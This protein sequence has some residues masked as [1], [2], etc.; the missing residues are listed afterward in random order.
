M[1]MVFGLRIKDRLD[2]ISN[3]SSW[4]ERIKLVLLVN[5]MWE[6]A[7]TQTTK[8]TDP[9]ELAKY[10]KSDAKARLIILDGVEDHLIPYLTGKATSWH[11]WEA[12]KTLFQNKNKN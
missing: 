3:Y 7:D 8:P 6:F 9:T 4:K 12:L 2:G 10:N 11:M 1:K 5:D